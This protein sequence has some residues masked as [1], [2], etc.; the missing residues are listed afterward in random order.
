MKKPGAE[1]MNI[2]TNSLLGF[3]DEGEVC[4][5]GVGEGVGEGV[6]GADGDVACGGVDS[7]VVVFFFDQSCV[8]QAAASHC[9][10]NALFDLRDAAHHE[11]L[12]FCQQAW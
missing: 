4:V 6:E 7:G 3:E 10:F 12:R 5:T 2:C 1:V 11:S 8:A 9:Y